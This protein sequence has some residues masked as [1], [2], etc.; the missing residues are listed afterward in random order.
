MWLHKNCI[1]TTEGYEQEEQE[2]QEYA[3]R[4]IVTE[5]IGWRIAATQLAGVSPKGTVLHRQSTAL[6]M[7][8]LHRYI[9]FADCGYTIN[10]LVVS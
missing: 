7:Q 10:V 2:L 6:W 9:C 3:S 1:S 5:G 4:R 8:A